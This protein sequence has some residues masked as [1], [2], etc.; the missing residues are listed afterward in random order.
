M[1]LSP[2]LFAFLMLPAIAACAGASSHVGTSAIPQSQQ[3]LMVSRAVATATQ[4]PPP[5][6]TAFPSSWGRIYP[7]QVFDSFPRTGT[8]MT[9][10]EI[11]ADAHRY[12]AVWG[13]FNPSAWYAAQPSVKIS[14]YYIPQEDSNAISGHDINWWLTNHPDWILY[15]CD[16]NNNPT[17]EYAYAPGVGFPDVP[18]DMHNPAVVDYQIRQSLGPY[19][20]ANHYKAAALDL[21]VFHNIMIGGNPNLGQTVIKG[22]YGC[23][24][25][26]NGTFVRRYT[27]PTDP[28][29][30][31]DLLNWV[32]TAHTDFTTDKTFAPHQLKIFVNHPPGYTTDPNELALMQNIDFNLLESGF[33]DY[34]NYKL[35][36]Y[37]GLFNE[38]V[39]W[40][41]FVQSQNVAVG[42]I[43]KFDNENKALS[44][45]EVEYTIATYL[46]ADEQGAYLYSAPNNLP[47]V[48]YGAEQWHPE[49]AT[50]IGTPCAELYGGSAYDPSNPQ[51]YYRRF[52][53]GM[54]VV[55][56]GSLPVTS[57]TATLPT[58]H[59]YKDLEKRTITNPLTVASNDGYVLLTTP[60]TG[61]Q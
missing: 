57:E 6:L 50:K 9:N 35:P 26:E 40:M 54:S 52:A 5:K 15:A 53:N 34:G 44:P 22:D 3:Q 45:I 18:L 36:A 17:M 48:G 1:Y 55:N 13:S 51:I 27:G 47:G 32:K 2:R 8:A 38:M 49:Y 41:K 31:T 11:A 42:I 21:V 58:N 7:Y 14:Q 59:T 25:Y 33:V 30:T 61:C 28:A 46:M 20:I 10:A 39:N 19:L 60:G 4:S 24:I 37:A 16:S 12:P 56:S 43:D 23:G 29:Y